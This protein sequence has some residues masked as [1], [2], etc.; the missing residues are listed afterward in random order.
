MERFLTPLRQALPDVD[1]DV[2]SARRTEVYERSSRASAA[3][4]ARA[5]R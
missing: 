3:S 4:G 1:V 2:E 5:S